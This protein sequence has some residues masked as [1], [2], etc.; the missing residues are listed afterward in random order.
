[1]SRSKQDAARA[2]ALSLTDDELRAWGFVNDQERLDAKTITKLYQSDRVKEASEMLETLG[3]WPRMLPLVI[4]ELK[5]KRTKSDLTTSGLNIIRACIA[6]F[7]GD[8]APITLHKVKT[9]YAR[10]FVKERRPR[11]KT[12]RAWLAS[13]EDRN[14]IPDHKTF[15]KTLQRLECDGPLIC[16]DRSGRPQK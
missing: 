8:P 15:R 7:A 12:V 11:G 4:D 2:Y 6:A 9:E 1:M 14:K 3:N 5:G 16:K 13:L 10:L